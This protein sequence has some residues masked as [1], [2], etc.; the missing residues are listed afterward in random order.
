MMSSERT[1]RPERNGRTA[2]S[3]SQ[4]LLQHVHKSWTLPQIQGD[5]VEVP[6]AR[7]GDG[8]GCDLS[9][10]DCSPRSTAD[11][12]RRTRF[13]SDVFGNTSVLT[14][15]LLGSGCAIG[16]ADIRDSELFS[17][18]NV[19]QGAQIDGALVLPEPEIVAGVRL[20]RAPA[21]RQ[22]A[23]PTARQPEATAS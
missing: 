14:R 20:R 10:S 17:E 11:R 21:L 1:A 7:H 22:M 6:Q 5:F 4:S 13:N 19:S 12:G 8:D 18:V 23:L 15:S 16:A 9:A 2:A 3:Q